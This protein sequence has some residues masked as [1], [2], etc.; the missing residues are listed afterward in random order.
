MQ[1]Y[2]NNVE[3]ILDIKPGINWNGESVEDSNER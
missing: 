2:Q 1:S 3:C